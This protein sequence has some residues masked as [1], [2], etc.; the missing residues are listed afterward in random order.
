[1]KVEVHPTGSLGQ[2]ELL[3]GLSGLAREAAKRFL[4]AVC[5]GSSAPGSIS[6]PNCLF[7]VVTLRG[8]CFPTVAFGASR[9][10]C[11]RN[12]SG[13]FKVN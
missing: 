4:E 6:R 10:N 2:E 11:L 1:M 3:K 9:D 8:N 5:C 7:M 12:T 13:G